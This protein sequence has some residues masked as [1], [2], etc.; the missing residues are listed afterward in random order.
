MITNKKFKETIYLYAE[1]KGRDTRLCIFE[2]H[3]YEM[4]NYGVSIDPDEFDE[5][6]KCMLHAM[7]DFKD[8]LKMKPDEDGE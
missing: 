1:G 4:H 3:R 8:R 6:E 2:S 5:F 7:N